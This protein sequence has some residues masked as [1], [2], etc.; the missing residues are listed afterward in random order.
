MEDPESSSKAEM[1]PPSP[2][3][4]VLLSQE[5]ILEV[6]FKSG[7]IHG[8]TSMKI[9]ISSKEIIPLLN[10]HVGFLG[11]IHLRD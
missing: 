7:G 6:D 11:T 4:F 5:T 9:G 2:L 1:A 8:A 3:T 10:F